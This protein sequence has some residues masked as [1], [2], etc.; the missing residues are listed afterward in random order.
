[1]E[2]TGY[3]QHVVDWERVACGVVGRA[4]PQHFGVFIDEVEQVLLIN[5]EVVVEACRAIL[6]IVYVGAHTIHSVGGVDGDY[7]VDAGTAEYAIGYVDALIASHSEEYAVGR[8]SANFSEAALHLQ[9]QGVGIAVKA[10]DAAVF[11]GIE[12]CE[13]FAGVF[14]AG[15]CVGRE[16]Q[17]V[18]AHE[19]V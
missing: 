2:P 16:A 13:S 6:Y 4:H 18:G 7:I 12:P 11:V 5:R 3:A 8:N 19:A 10:V 14:V 1:M 15:A 17:Y 9:L